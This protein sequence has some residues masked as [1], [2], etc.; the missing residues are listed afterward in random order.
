MLPQEMLEHIYSFLCDRELCALRAA[1]R[2]FLDSVDEY[3]AHLLAQIDGTPFGKY[4]RAT[5]GRHPKSQCDICS[6]EDRVVFQSLPSENDVDIFN[7]HP[8]D[9]IQCNGAGCPIFISFTT[10]KSCSSCPCG[11]FCERC[12]SKYLFSVNRRE[13]GSLRCHRCRDT[14]IGCKICNKLYDR[15]QVDWCHYCNTYVCSPC[16]SSF[17]ICFKCGQCTFCHDVDFYECGLCYDSYCE[18]CENFIG[19]ACKDC[20]NERYDISS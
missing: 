13:Y 12:A 3:S 9:I 20:F 8:M 6:G 19:G 4:L 17:S 18:D 11:F 2:F 16:D 14:V 5:R 7:T 10:A 1:N 15:E